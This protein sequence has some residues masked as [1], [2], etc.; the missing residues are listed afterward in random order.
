MNDNEIMTLLSNNI[1]SVLSAVQAVAG[2]IFTVLFLR[3]N[4]SATEFEK[5]KAGQFKEVADKLLSEGKMSHMEYLKSNNFLNVAK[6]A[7]NT[8]VHFH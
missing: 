2:T 4:T 8:Y 6:L 1:P 5:I 7:D 3:N